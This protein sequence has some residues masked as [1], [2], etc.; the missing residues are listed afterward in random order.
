MKTRFVS[1][2]L[3][4][5][6]DRPVDSAWIREAIENDLDGE[7]VYPREEDTDPS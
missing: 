2:V 4:A 1:L 7:D 3:K 6:D 5:N